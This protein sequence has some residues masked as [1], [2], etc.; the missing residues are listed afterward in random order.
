MRLLIFSDAEVIGVMGT[1]SVW[2]ALI[3]TLRQLLIHRRNQLRIVFRWIVA[4]PIRRL[5][6][7]TILRARC[8]RLADARLAA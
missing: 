6:V 8:N 1:P 4:K 3:V 5:S 7:V 2:R